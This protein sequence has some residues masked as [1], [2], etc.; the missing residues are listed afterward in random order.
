MFVYVTEKGKKTS[1]RASMVRVRAR[2]EGSDLPMWARG[3]FIAACPWATIWCVFIPTP[4]FEVCEMVARQQPSETTSS[5]QQIQIF[6]FSQRVLNKA[7]GCCAA[8]GNTRNTGCLSWLVS[9]VSAAFTS[10]DAHALLIQTT[11]TVIKA[12][13]DLFKHPTSIQD[14]ASTSTSVGHCL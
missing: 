1:G 5:V 4:P 9:E 13:S 14:F 8:Q 12:I 6:L 3:C 10:F 11:Y 7:E 2:R